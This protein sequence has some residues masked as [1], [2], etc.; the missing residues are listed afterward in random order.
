MLVSASATATMQGVSNVLAFVVSVLLARLLGARGY[1]L[2]TLAISWAGF[3]MI[4]ALFGFE[5]FLVREISVYEVHEQ[6]S[7]M[8][9]LLQRANQ[10]VL[11]A[12]IAIASCGIFVAITWMSPALRGPFCVAMLLVPLNCLILLRQGAM[13]AIG[14]IVTAQ[15][16]EYLIRPVLIL[17]GVIALDLLG[18]H[19]LTPTTAAVVNVTAVAV[20]F[21][22]G[23]ILLVRALPDR[24]RHVRV[25]FATRDWLRGSFPMMLISGVWLA[26]G[27]I[28][29]LVVG[30]LDGPKSA[31]V[32]SVVQRGGE[33]IVVLLFATNMPLAPA[34]AR[35]Y[36]RGDR[37]GL[38]HTTE[39]MARASFIVSVP[40]ALTLMLFPNIY[41]D[42]F[43]SDFRLGASA[44]AIVAF[45]QLINATAGPSGNVL[46]MTGHERVAARGVMVGLV[47]N[48][49]LA[50][51]L[52]PSLGVTGGG[53]AYASSLILWNGI[54]VLASR[55]HVGVNVTAFRRLAMSNR[56]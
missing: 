38:E 17:A 25:A 55:R 56:P 22:V 20:A 39:R 23:A 2:Y 37:E 50:I 21:V 30:T 47:V 29:T 27:Y 6:W 15:L 19:T 4:P 31:G 53:I 16:P 13:Q 43:G 44:M 54:L 9:G 52:V 34:V 12:S 33:V 1:G 5:R 35:L 49:L 51:A 24:L 7:L 45:G 40:I 18:N 46:V 41:L 14:R 28:T 3:L 36:A 10:F 26:N 11:M 48:I 8:K 32:Y 42:L